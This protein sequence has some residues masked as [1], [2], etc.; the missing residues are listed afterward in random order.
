MQGQTLLLASGSAPKPLIGLYLEESLY[1]N[2]YGFKTETLNAKLQVGF[3]IHLN[4]L[5]NYP[6]I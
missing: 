3:Q 5:Q 2:K 1:L 4:P 6:E